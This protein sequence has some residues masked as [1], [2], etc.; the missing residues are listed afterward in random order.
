MNK[1]LESLLEATTTDLLRKQKSITKLFPEFPSRVKAI[2][3]MGGIRLARTD[4]KNWFF[5]VHS[6]TKNGV[7]YENVL[8]FVN[9]VPELDRLIRN[10]KLWIK[11]RSRIDLN[12]LAHE[13]LR[14]INV[15]IS[16]NC[17]AAQYWGP[18]YILSLSKYDAKYGDREGRP[19]KI[20]NPKKYGAYCKHMANVI[21]VLPFYKTTL[22]K[23]L[24]EFYDKDIKKFE[25]ETKK[26]Y[27]WIKKAAVK[28]GKKKE[29]EEKPKE[30]EEVEAA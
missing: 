6:G 26:E 15:R 5:K 21:K 8:H 16:C 14:K 30:E 17:P 7:W 25:E 1:L 10:R 9:I 22:A 3:G 19:P 24:T 11:D 27:G 12:K 20:R 13:F 28:L 18:N 23:W 4:V 2:A 29:E